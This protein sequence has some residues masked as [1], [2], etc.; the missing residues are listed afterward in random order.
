MARTRPAP[1]GL[2]LPLHRAFLRLRS[3]RRPGVLVACLGPAL[4]ALVLAATFAEASWML[5]SP[6]WRSKDFSIV[7]R[8]GLYHIFWTRTSI[9]D[10]NGVTE[11]ALGHAVSWDLYNW[12]QRDSVI[13]VRPGEWDH[14]RIWA[15][16]VVESDGVWYMFYTGVTDQPGS[17]AFHQRTGL[18]VSTDLDTWTRVDEPIYDCG[19]IPWSYCDPLL[20]AGG[21]LRD[22]FVMQDPDEAGRWLM[23][24]TAIPA[25][26]PVRYVVDVA[27]TVDGFE[28]WED[29]GPLWTTYHATTGRELCESP[30]L[31]SHDGTWYLLFTTNAGNPL[32]WATGSS[33]TGD[34]AT[35]SYRGTLSSMLG[36][37][38]QFW[39]ASEHLRDG[40]VDYLAFVNF[41]RVDVRRMVWKPDG[42]FTI[43]QPDFFHVKSLR[44]DR[45][46]VEVG[47]PARLEIRSVNASGR[48][49]KFSAHELDTDGTNE[50]LSAASLGFADSVWVADTL[51]T[52]PWV[53]RGWSDGDDAD[54]TTAELS[55]R[56]ADG[57]AVAPTLV[58]T[59]IGGCVGTGDPGEIIDPAIVA[60]ADA[61]PTLRALHRTPVSD[62][63]AVLV[64]TDV[65]VRGRL[66]IYDVQG[67]RLGTLADR[68]FPA[69]ASVV[70]W[71][72]EAAGG[73][74]APG[75]RFV[76]LVT[77][78]GDRWTRIVVTR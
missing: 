75:V 32:A 4:V 6:G 50:P 66:E 29:V 31:F 10:P 53:A 18:A 55:W 59:P 68:E 37:D 33:P 77:P 56:V 24:Q 23:Y 63:P 76:R 1:E 48:W 13:P 25:S 12:T 35:W 74:A 5:P 78:H 46:S 57:T 42:T 21:N 7:K 16:H 51:V 36:F 39:F 67:R 3:I 47:V 54:S 40:D 22:V 11:T 9:A 15:P 43:A 41:D 44:W 14:H 30:H 65:P 60:E 72:R 69:G 61:G 62:G 28:S 34:L 26:D 70:P 73:P 19:D 45:D 38:T 71:S 2:L 27:A 8:E 17:Y 58:V 52:V 20:P 49:V 64:E